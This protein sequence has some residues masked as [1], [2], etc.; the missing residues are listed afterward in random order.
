MYMLAFSFLRISKE[1]S[2]LP[3]NLTLFPYSLLCIALI[4]H[5]LK[6]SAFNLRKT[7]NERQVRLCCLINTLLVVLNF[8]CF[9]SCMWRHLYFAF[10]TIAF[11]TFTFNSSIPNRFLRLWEPLECFRKFSRL[12]ELQEYFGKFF[13]MYETV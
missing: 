12:E 9:F 6:L 3:L 5:L 2:K 10:L 11:T 13:E 4:S 1:N 8:M 7:N